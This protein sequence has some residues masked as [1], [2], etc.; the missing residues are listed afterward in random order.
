MNLS[1]V[2]LGDMG[3]WSL[4]FGAATTDVDSGNRRPS[5]IILLARGTQYTT[6]RSSDMG[7]PRMNR[8]HTNLAV[9]QL[10]KAHYATGSVADDL[11][12]PVCLY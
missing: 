12:T 6:S 11:P 1:A 10:P 5:H 4:G 7:V 8:P 2:G 3:R 9:Y